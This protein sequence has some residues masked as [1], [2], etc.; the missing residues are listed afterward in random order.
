MASRKS[1]LNGP[2]K[3]TSYWP[4]Y[5]AE[6][7]NRIGRPPLKRRTIASVAAMAL[8]LAPAAVLAQYSSTSDAPAVSAVNF[9]SQDAPA[10]GAKSKAESKQGST[11]AFSAVGIAANVSPLGVGGQLATNLNSHINVRVEGS[12]F[13]YTVST[14][15]SNGFAI[16][17]KLNLASMGAAV[18]LYP[19][20]AGWRISP[21]VL[22]YNNNYA[23]ATYVATPGASFTLNNVT[24]YSASGANAVQ[25]TG[26]VG[27]GDGTPAF[28]ITTGWGNIAKTKGHWSVPFEV[29]IALIKAPT[30]GITL[31]GE[32][33]LDAALTQ[34]L[35]VATNPTIQANL[36]AQVAKYQSDLD[37]L[38]TYPI[39]S[40]GIS[41]SI[42]KN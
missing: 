38:K 14:I 24:Y 20:H 25:G 34:C 40:I 5:D 2:Q 41:Y 18:D 12:F 42:H 7:F 15:N 1:D 4:E 19:F 33:C 28:T 13:N 6:P 8:V 32:G 27:L 11:K 36:A 10:G 35:D 31:T 22:F 30:L 21:G 29:G 39:I 23:D 17:P 37:P 9:F 16:N 26:K 3:F